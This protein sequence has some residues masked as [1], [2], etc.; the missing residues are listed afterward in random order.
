M[1]R[2]Y[3]NIPPGLVVLEAEA[4][5]FRQPR[6]HGHHLLPGKVGLGGHAQGL[7][8]VQPPG[9]VQAALAR[10]QPRQVILRIFKVCFVDFDSF[11]K[12]RMR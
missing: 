4:G 7:G 8:L 10:F 6:P 12:L 9:H 3:L 2:V 11:I 5:Q 1:Y